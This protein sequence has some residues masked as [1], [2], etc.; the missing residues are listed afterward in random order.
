MIYVSITAL[1]FGLVESHV[2]QPAQASR[3]VLNIIEWDGTC[4][5]TV[6]VYTGAIKLREPSV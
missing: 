2:D 5:H 1:K 6:R 4:I 3:P